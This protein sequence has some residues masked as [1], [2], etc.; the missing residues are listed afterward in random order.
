MVER[1]APRCGAM[2]WLALALIAAAPACA[3]RA[4][5]G[6]PKGWPA[7]ADWI[8]DGRTGQRGGFD[9]MIEDLA[10][11]DV[12]FIGEDHHNPHH[13][14]AQ[15][16]IAEALLA[17]KPRLAL[18]M[19]MLQ[20]DAQATADRWVSGEI[21]LDAF[22][23]ETDWRRTWAF[24]IELYRPILELAREKKMPVVA[25][26]TPSA[27]VK[28]V[29]EVGVDG[30]A[31]EERAALPEMDLTSADYQA[32]FREAFGKFHEMPEDRFQRFFSIQVLWDE[33]MAE[34]VARAM[35]DD[36]AGSRRPMV[37]LAGYMHLTR[38]LGIPSR[39]ERRL[40]AV[41]SRVVLAVP[42]EEDTPDEIRSAVSRRDA[43]WLWITPDGEEPK[44]GRARADR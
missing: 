27:T 5:R 40:P 26:N 39:V 36:A 44:L 13:H 31:P 6:A 20:T 32:L 37:V 41:K 38:R 29:R 24:P 8:V 25:L 11:A 22:L 42:V 34:S 16:R 28:R 4:A 17:R 43:D 12:V 15:R 2:I 14:E 21:D 19:E 35:R 18:G 3:H 7:D 10:G 23:R 1:M 33:T 30:L 9:R